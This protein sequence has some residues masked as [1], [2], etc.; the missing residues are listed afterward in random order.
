MKTIMREKAAQASQRVEEEVAARNAVA[1]RLIEKWSHKRGLGL[2][3]GGF[4]KIYEAN[5]RTARNLAIVLENQ[6]RHLKTLTETQISNAF[7]STPQTVVKVI[8]LGYPNSIRGEV[9][10]EWAMTTMK[11][12][13]YKIET[14]YDMTAR[15]STINSVMYESTSDRYASEIEETT[16]NGTATATFTGTLSTVP[17]RPYM[18]QII[19]NGAPIA[20]DNGSGVFVGSLL[21][22]VTPSTIDYTTGNYSIVF[23]SA[24]TVNDSFVIRYSFNSEVSTLYSTQGHVNINLVGYDFRAHPFPIGFSWSKMTEL[25]MDSALSSDAEEVL[26]T[27]G[28]DELKKDLDFQA[29][30]M[31]YRGSNWT[32]PVQFNTDWAAAGAD[33]DYANTQSVVKALRNA[34]QLTYESLMRGGEAT[35]YVAGPKAVTYLTNHK[36]YVPENAPVAVG[37]YKAGTLNGIPVYQAPSSIVPTNEI[38]CVYKNNRQESNDSALVTGTYVPLYRTQTL[39]YSSFH[40]ESAL[41]FFGDMRLQ[42]PK[43]LT[44]VVLNGLA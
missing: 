10:T 27:A 6:E 29:L 42:E 38:M 24:L 34:S 16:V 17:V 12:T 43:Y 20:N 21:S 11:D 41:A 2:D 30:R 14:I 18:L 22:A 5:S 28:A 31:A 4:E 23:A 33:S 9:F 7:Q 36:L 40:K 26:I 3:N 37:G 39:E 25:L 13:F 35:S 8:R 15:G 19:L 44:R 32:T 1:D